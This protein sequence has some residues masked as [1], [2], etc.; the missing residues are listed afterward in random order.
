MIRVNIESLPQADPH[1]AETLHTLT[2]T[3]TGRVPGDWQRHS[4]MV[5][6]LE[7][8]AEGR[9]ERGVTTIRVPTDASV[10]ELV[11]SAMEALCP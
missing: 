9:T 10:M 4:Y 11:L 6:L 7:P 2:I 8:R 1:R 3:D 5:R